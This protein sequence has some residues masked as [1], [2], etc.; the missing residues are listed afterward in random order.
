MLFIC[1]CGGGGRGVGWGG[2]GGRWVHTCVC[3]CMK[4][5]EIFVFPLLSLAVLFVPVCVQLC[6]HQVTLP[7]YDCSRRLW[8]PSS[9]IATLCQSLTVS[10]GHPWK[11]CQK[12]CGALCAS[13]ALG[14]YVC[15]LVDFPALCMRISGMDLLGRLHVLPH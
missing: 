6:L 3:S 11:N 13:T 9:V 10:T 5:L 15:W 4:F 14:G 8:R 12:T 1:V 7:V 2:G